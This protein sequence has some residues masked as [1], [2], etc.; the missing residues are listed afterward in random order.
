MRYVFAFCVCVADVQPACFWA[1]DML[2]YMVW[3]VDLTCNYYSSTI[4]GLLC[5]AVSQRRGNST[6]TGAAC[7]SC[8]QA[9]LRKLDWSSNRAFI[10]TR[11][12]LF[13]DSECLE[14]LSNSISWRHCPNR[15]TWKTTFVL[16]LMHYVPQLFLYT[17]LLS[18]NFTLNNF[19]DIL[20][21]IMAF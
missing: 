11:L 17:F 19:C 3:F 10:L 20:P 12:I 7:F 1:V 6:S 13:S 5:F 15:L 4:H 16:P 2:I 8:C 18:C 21:L 14:K 9:D